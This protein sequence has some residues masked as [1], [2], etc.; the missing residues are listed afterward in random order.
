M[1]R[2]FGEKIHFFLTT[3]FAE[4]RIWNLDIEA[5]REKTILKIN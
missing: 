4:G 2:D 5:F 1:S 3:L